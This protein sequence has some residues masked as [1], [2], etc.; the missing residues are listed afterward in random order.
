MIRGGLLGLLEDSGFQGA[1]GNT[2]SCMTASAFLAAEFIGSYTF[3]KDVSRLAQKLHSWLQQICLRSMGPGIA[4]PAFC[5][6]E[7]FQWAIN[8][9]ASP[10]HIWRAAAMDC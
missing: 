10:L 1:A 8:Y 5:P 6:L 7:E 2:C 4:F 9:A 3:S